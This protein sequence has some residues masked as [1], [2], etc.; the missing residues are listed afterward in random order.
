MRD[1]THL[2][3]DNILPVKIFKLYERHYIIKE[4]K[5]VISK[6]RHR[7]VNGGGEEGDTNNMCQEIL[8]EPLSDVCDYPNRTTMRK[9][10]S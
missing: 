8:V 9:L 7:Y 4:H 2:S 6:K 1:V 10:T 5:Q 3:N